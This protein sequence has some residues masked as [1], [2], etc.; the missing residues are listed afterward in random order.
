MGGSIF[1]AFYICNCNSWSV[2]FFIAEGC[3]NIYGRRRIDFF[4][5]LDFF[6]VYF[7]F[8]GGNFTK[9]NVQLILG[10][11]IIPMRIFRALRKEI[12]IDRMETIEKTPKKRSKVPRS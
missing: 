8:F 3:F 5:A 1:T 2:L 9:V 10:D 7:F 11:E 6:P 12:L 4:F